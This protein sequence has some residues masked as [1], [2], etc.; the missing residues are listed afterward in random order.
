MPPS[1]FAEKWKI[2]SFRI[3]SFIFYQVPGADTAVIAVKNVAE[4]TNGG[5]LCG[6]SFSSADGTTTAI[7][8]TG[9]V[10][11]TMKMMPVY[12]CHKPVLLGK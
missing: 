2:L 7:A 4:L 5:R 9:T 11:G 3:Y 1:L 10:C 8:T 6:R 12:H